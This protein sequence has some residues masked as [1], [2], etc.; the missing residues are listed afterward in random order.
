MEPN[1]LLE[2][3]KQTDFLIIENIAGGVGAKKLFLI[4]V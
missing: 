4:Q 1:L 3:H 2:Q